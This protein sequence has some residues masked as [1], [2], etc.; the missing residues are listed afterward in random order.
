MNVAPVFHQAVLCDL[1]S[2]RPRVQEEHQ[3]GAQLQEQVLQPV[4]AEPTLSEPVHGL[5]TDPDLRLEDDGL[6]RHHGDRE[7]QLQRQPLPRHR[8]AG[9][10]QNRRILVNM[11]K[12]V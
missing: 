3:I 5:G 9:T 1:S 6:A 2:F 10:R 4:D 8:W 7:R 11:H 12:Q